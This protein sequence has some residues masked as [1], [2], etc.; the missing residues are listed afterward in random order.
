MKSRI[1][2]ILILIVGC[3]TVFILFSHFVMNLGSF[4]GTSFKE[5][6]KRVQGRFYLFE[7]PE[8]AEDYRFIC[9]NYGLG[10]DYAE[11]FTLY[12]TEYDEFVDEVKMKE[13]GSVVGYHE[14]L[15]YTGLNV[16][17]TI[18]YYDDNGNYIGFP[19][20]RIKYVIDD[21]INNYTILYY[22]AYDGAGASKK[23]IITNTGTGRIVIYG[24]GSN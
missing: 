9:H 14:E 21:D 18:D 3:F 4:R 6:K 22:D 13:S 17:E 5:S 16:S 20:S 12:G 11:A 2:K 8:D 15:D 19:S 7:L 10:G 23:A 24:Y 1:V